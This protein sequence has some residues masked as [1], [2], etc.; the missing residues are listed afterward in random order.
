MLRLVRCC[1]GITA[2]RFQGS[3]APSNASPW[4]VQTQR[5]CDADVIVACEVAVQCDVGVDTMHAEVQWET[6]GGEFGGA[7]SKL[8]DAMRLR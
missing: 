3:S 7:E 5:Q 2:A 8:R 6:R 1:S 4:P